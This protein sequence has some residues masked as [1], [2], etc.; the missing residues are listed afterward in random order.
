MKIKWLVRLLV[1][2]ILGVSLAIIAKADGD[3]DGTSGPQGPQGIQ[4]VQGP[5][6]PAGIAGQPG[7]SGKAGATGAQ[8]TMGPQG[9]TR[10]ASA[11]DPRLDVEVREYD[12]KRWALSSYASFGM[13]AST[14]RYVV[15]QRLT[16]KL[17][18]SYEQREIAK[19]RKALGLKEAR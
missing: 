10:D 2:C 4:G 6:G 16:V 5:V 8:G 18:Q 13:Q 15:G 17:G 11:V 19:L 12:A 1:V 3:E 7:A 14:S 9:P